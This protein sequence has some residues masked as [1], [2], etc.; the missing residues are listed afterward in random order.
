MEKIKCIYFALFLGL[1]LIALFPAPSAS[2]QAACE[3]PVFKYNL[4]TAINQD[5]M[6]K[7]GTPFDPNINPYIVYGVENG[8]GTY[9]IRVLYSNAPNK[10]Y[11]ITTGGPLPYSINGTANDYR[12]TNATVDIYSPADPYIGDIAYAHCLYYANR[13]TYEQNYPHTPISP[14]TYNEPINPPPAI[15]SYWTDEK[16]AQIISVVVAF[17]V[18]WIIVRSFRFGKYE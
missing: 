5:S 11:H 10:S 18:T 12:T 9:A 3:P 2:A 17:F 1:S 7:T 14:Y 6:Q 8:D 15:D 16:V 13:L 4:I